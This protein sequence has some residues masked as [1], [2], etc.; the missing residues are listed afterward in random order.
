MLPA[1][2]VLCPFTHKDIYFETVIWKT[3]FPI[4][5][6]TNV[7]HKIKILTNLKKKHSMI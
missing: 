4:E 5:N 2:Q 7:A 1:V 6:V 3:K